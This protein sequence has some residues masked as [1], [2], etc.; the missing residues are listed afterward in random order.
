MHSLDELTPKKRLLLTTKFDADEKASNALLTA[1][2]RIPDTLASNIK[3]RPEVLR[4]LKATRDE[5]GKK[6]KKLEDQEKAGERKLQADKAKKDERE[7]K[8]KGM[9][10]E[11]Q[12]K[13][14]EKERD[15]DQRKLMGRKTMK[16]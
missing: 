16:A 6:I 15:R 4:R 3:L 12:R 2:L 11:E 13:Y 9:S 10:A 1:F 14:L 7:K 8:L 5:E